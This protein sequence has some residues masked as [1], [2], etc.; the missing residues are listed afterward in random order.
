MHPGGERGSRIYAKASCGHYTQC[1]IRMQLLR[2]YCSHLQIDKD[3]HLMIIFWN[4]QWMEGS[5]CISG[6]K[7]I[8]CDERNYL[9]QAF[10]EDSQLH[11][12]S[13]EFKK[14]PYCTFLLERKNN[15]CKESV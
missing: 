8:M 15:R 2:K 11:V 3:N 10:M 7:K 13:M 9:G 4:R 12:I 5:Q 14:K 1:S 6:M